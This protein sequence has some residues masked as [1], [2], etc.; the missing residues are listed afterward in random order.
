MPAAGVARVWRLRPWQDVAHEYAY[1]RRA[2]RDRTAG[3]DAR[4]SAAREVDRR[5]L[6]RRRQ[7]LLDSTQHAGLYRHIP[8]RTGLR[9]G[10]GHGHAVRLDLRPRAAER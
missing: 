1:R 5:A 8:R 6:S 4:G 7:V 10:L 3:T 2:R 9:P